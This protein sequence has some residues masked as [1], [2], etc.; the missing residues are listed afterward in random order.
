MKKLF[1]TLLP[2]I[3]LFSLAS[4]DDS[5]TETRFPG[6]SNRHYKTFGAG[7]D[8][9]DINIDIKGDDIIMTKRHRGDEVKITHEYDLIINGKKV[10]MDDRQRELVKDFYH[11]MIDLTEYAAVIGAEGAKIG[12]R[13]AVIGISALGKVFKLLDSDYDTEDLE[14]EVE[15]EARGLERDAARLEKKADQIEWMADELENLY[16]EMEREFIELRELHWN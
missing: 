2:L 9:D 10:E 16:G 4:A 13:G 11:N 12:A 15:H 1:L 6:E 7:C 3:L 5:A 14:R 8:W